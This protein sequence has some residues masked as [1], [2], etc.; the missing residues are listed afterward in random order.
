MSLWLVGEKSHVPQ[1]ETTRDSTCPKLY[2]SVRQITTLFSVCEAP[3]VS[4]DARA[5]AGVCDHRPLLTIWPTFSTDRT[6]SPPSAREA[7]P[8]N[9]LS[10]R[11]RKRCRLHIWTAE[12]CDAN[13]AREYNED[14]KFPR[15]AAVRK[16]ANPSFTPDRFVA[17]SQCSRRL[18]R[19]LYRHIRIL[20]PCFRHSVP[21]R[22]PHHAEVNDGPLL[23]LG[24]YGVRGSQN[25]LRF[26]ALH[27]FHRA[28]QV[29]TQYFLRYISFCSQPRSVTFLAIYVEP[30]HVFY[31]H[32]EYMRN[33]R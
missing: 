26:V 18:H 22:S 3:D 10:S 8:G 23:L 14:N 33:S 17:Y 4:H 11:I 24:M 15:A 31:V 30:C 9:A 32:D 25:N 16:P 2:G 1:R 5:A 13:H 29:C 19:H 6:L 27:H 12:E 28:G 21:C 7:G 20:P